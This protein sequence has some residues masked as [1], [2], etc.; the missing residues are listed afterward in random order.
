MTLCAHVGTDIKVLQKYAEAF[1]TEEEGQSVSPKRL[2]LS[3]SPQS[4][5]T[6]KNNMDIFTAMRTS[7]S[8]LIMVHSV[9]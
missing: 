3:A 4:V 2:H 8:T 1:S 6:Q 9:V 7:N 5:T